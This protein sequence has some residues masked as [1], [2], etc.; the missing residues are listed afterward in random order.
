MNTERFKAHEIDEVT[1]P[2]KLEVVWF[3]AKP[4][5]SDTAIRNII[6]CSFY[7]PPGSR[8]KTR[9]DLMDHNVGSLFML[10][11]KNE[12]CAIYVCGDR[13]N[14]NI[15]PLQDNTLKLRQIVTLP[16][17]RNKILDKLGLS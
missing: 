7:S 6:L 9:N 4:V 17:R 12:N 16:T 14:L 11:T 1:V 3:M 2:S 5:N 13:N 8:L 10:T 15:T